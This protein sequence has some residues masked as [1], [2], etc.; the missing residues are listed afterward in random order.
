MIDSVR[1]WIKEPANLVAVALVSVSA[2]VIIVVS[3]FG[4][5]TSS[6][7]ERPDIP[8][9]TLEDGSTQDLCWWYDDANGWYL[10]INKGES[11]YVPRTGDLITW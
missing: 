3:V 10:N 4:D 11:V 9:C 6:A 1:K 2:V 8:R 5:R 7:P